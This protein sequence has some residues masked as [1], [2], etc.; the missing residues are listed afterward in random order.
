MRVLI[1]NL[2]VANFSGTETVVELLADA[3]DLDVLV[4][5]VG[6]GGLLSGTAIS[7]RAHRASIKVVG[8]EPDTADSLER[9]FLEA[10]EDRS[11]K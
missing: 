8:V 10:T 7:A 11:E 5:P 2:F 9:L 6:G 3:P 4:T 1:T